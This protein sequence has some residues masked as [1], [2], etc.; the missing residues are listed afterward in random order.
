MRRNAPYWMAEG[1]GSRSHSI[2]SGDPRLQS[3]HQNLT[4]I[5]KNLFII[6]QRLDPALSSAFS[7]AQA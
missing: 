1:I 5:H 4:F 3:I 6:N 7:S 2:Y